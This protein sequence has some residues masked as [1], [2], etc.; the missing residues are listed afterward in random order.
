MTDLHLPNALT[1]MSG[2]HLANI[3]LAHVGV[4]LS[5]SRFYKS[6]VENFLWDFLRWDKRVK[7]ASHVA[8]ALVEWMS[9]HVVILLGENH[10]V[11]IG[12]HMSILPGNSII[13]IEWR[14]NHRLA[15]M[16]I[17]THCS[18]QS[19]QEKDDDRKQCRRKQTEI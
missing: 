16:Q 8:I 12:M 17:Y 7:F 3:F 10:C 9:L 6:K 11:C 1:S 5:K 19:H 13:Y 14:Y 4:L 18:I 15:Q 2:L